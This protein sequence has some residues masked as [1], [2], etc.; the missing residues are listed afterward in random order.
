[1][2][3]ISLVA[4]ALVLVV[5]G[6]RKEEGVSREEVLTTLNALEHKL[7][8]LHYRVGQ[9]TWE[10]YSTGASDRSEERRAGKRGRW[11]WIVLD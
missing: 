10:L 4:I 8:W 11:W 9:E 3:R 2:K 6:C 7:E 1:M 5:G